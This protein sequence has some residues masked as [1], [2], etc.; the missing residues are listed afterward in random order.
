MLE[1]NS[2]RS[3]ILDRLKNS[4]QHMKI[5]ASSKGECYSYSTIIDKDGVVTSDDRNIYT[6]IIDKNSD[7]ILIKDRIDDML[8]SKV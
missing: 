1:E 5:T 6:H 8:K 2:Y 3:I 7:F 4:S